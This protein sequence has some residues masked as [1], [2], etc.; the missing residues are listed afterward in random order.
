MTKIPKI[1]TLIIVAGLIFGAGY[2]FLKNPYF[3]LPTPKLPQ[4][5]VFQN[6][7]NGCAN[8]FLYKISEDD[9]I[10]I[11]V[12][13]KGDTL[14]LSKQEKTFE[15]GKTDGLN[16]EILVGQKIAQLYCNDVL[17]LD[18]P[19]PR[20]LIGKSGTAT[21]SLGDNVEWSAPNWERGYKATIN[22]SNVHFS[23]E[24]GQDIN[25][26]LDNLIFKDVTVGWFPG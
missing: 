5:F 21:I 8:I 18:Q 20:K 14:H 25:V 23:D 10:G 17:Y 24:N 13:A 26:I 2:F 7:A 6:E 1:I 11:S 19:K 4:K 22:L 3:P 12:S 15:I 16:V 9:T